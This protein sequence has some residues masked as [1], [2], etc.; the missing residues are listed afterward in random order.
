VKK[1]STIYEQIII[2]AERTRELRQQRY[3]SLETGMFSPV[4]NKKLPRTVDTVIDEFENKEIG[5]EYLGRA[6]TRVAEGGTRKRIQR[7]K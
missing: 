1:D 6:I 4:E 2:T 3:G 7:R 5:R